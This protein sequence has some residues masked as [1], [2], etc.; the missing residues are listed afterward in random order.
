MSSSWQCALAFCAVVAC[1]K[2]A[3]DPSTAAPVLV[4]FAPPVA[5]AT[6]PPP[7]LAGAHP[8]PRDPHSIV[9]PRRFVSSDSGEASPMSLLVGREPDASHRTGTV[10]VGEVLV[11]D[12]ALAS[13][14]VE[15]DLAKGVAVRRVKLPLPPTA[16][17]SRIIRSD[18]AI[19]VMASEYNGALYYLHLTTQLDVVANEQLGTV[20]VSGP[21][22]IAT[23]GQLTAILAN[24][25]TDPKGSA[26]RLD[27]LFI[28]AFGPSG[29][30]AGE[31]LLMA[32]DDSVYSTRLSRN[33]A[34]VG[35]SIFVLLR[36]RNARARVEELA[37]DLK[38]VRRIELPSR[39]E[40]L[41]PGFELT[42]E[43][44]HLVAD[45]GERER[46]FAIPLD[47]SRASRIVRP[48]RSGFRGRND[49]SDQVEM[50][51]V[52]AALCACGKDTCLEWTAAP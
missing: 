45:L 50:G 7:P 48:Q 15:W 18:R 5:S 1:S 22:A 9:L 25:T 20:S 21:N 24:G 28:A 33:M 12:D 44:D 32:P 37:S 41:D 35:G 38:T 47:L 10:F 49:C 17:W 16:A 2:Q 51:Q 40:A 23:D 8:P 27:G 29:R 3:T 42:L 31:R 14:V 13:T 46:V 19:H 11:E 30:L 39:L 4:V 36:D 34:V 6:A 43:G 52:K 26:G